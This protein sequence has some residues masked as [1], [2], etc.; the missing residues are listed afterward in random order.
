MPVNGLNHV[1]IV[2][3]DV[4]ATVK[5][6]EA[7][8]GLQ[9]KPLPMT[10]PADLQILWLADSHGQPIIHLQGYNPD[11]HPL[12]P[13]DPNGT[14]DHVA[15]TCDDFEGLRKRCDEQG[16]SYSV[17]DRQFGKLRQL[18]LTDPNNVAL[19]LNFAGE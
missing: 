19:E 14:V 4:A 16:I 8:L 18:F 1:N 10:P 5:F 15:F 6:Y 7:V 11:R 2:T 17:N 13:G 9:V 3:K 12:E